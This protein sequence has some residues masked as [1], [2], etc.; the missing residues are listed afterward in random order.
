MIKA[1]ELATLLHFTVTVTSVYKY[2][3]FKFCIPNVVVVQVFTFIGILGVPLL[4][5]RIMKKIK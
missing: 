2:P 4:F 1:I 5:K 3:A